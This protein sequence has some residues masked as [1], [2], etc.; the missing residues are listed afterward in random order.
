MRIYTKTG[1]RGQTGLIG[2]QRV[3]K[4]DPRVEAYGTLDELTAALGVVR[5]FLPVD[6]ASSHEVLAHIQRVL[7]DLGSELASLPGTRKV[8]WVFDPAEI[9]KL[10]RAIDEMETQL[11]PLKQF[12]LPGG[13]PAGALAHLARTVAR[14]AERTIVTLA[15]GSEVQPGILAYINRLSDFLFVLSR[16]VNARL[17]AAEELVR[18]SDG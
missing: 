10:E 14:R 16:F 3:P 15:A 2:G 17:G 6:L 4:D 5:A 11:E 13:H 8:P 12:I 9:D 18:A 1:D 7:F